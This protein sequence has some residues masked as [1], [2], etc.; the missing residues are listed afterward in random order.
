MWNPEKILYRQLV[1]LEM[2][3][4]IFQQYY[5]FILLIIYV[6]SE[7]NELTVIVNLPITHLK[8]VSTLPCEMQ[9]SFVWWKVCCLPLNVGGSEKANCVVCHWWLWWEPVMLRC[10]ATWMSGK[11]HHSKCSTWPSSAWIHASSLF[12]HWLI[13]SSITHCWNSARVSTIRCC[14]SCILLIGAWYQASTSCHRYSNQPGSGHDCN[15]DDTTYVDFCCRLLLRNLLQQ[16]KSVC[17]HAK[18]HNKRGFKW[19]T[20]MFF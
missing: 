10:V 3:N 8:S 20:M 7:K 6:I 5:L 11:Q 13:A 12:C 15:P 14:N 19:E 16:Q 18:M 17:N 9:N 4:V 1:S 2:Q